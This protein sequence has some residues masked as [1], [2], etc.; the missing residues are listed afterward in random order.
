MRL[1]SLR[2]ENRSSGAS[3]SAGPEPDPRFDRDQELRSLLTTFAPLPRQDELP[4]EEP[5]EEEA[6]M[7][8]PSEPKEEADTETEAK[9]EPLEPKNDALEERM[10]RT[11]VCFSNVPGLCPPEPPRAGTCCI[12]KCTVGVVA[13]GASACSEC[14]LVESICEDFF[15]QRRGTGNEEVAQ[16]GE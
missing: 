3:S 15:S 1:G 12:C 14:S 9:E 16:A 8:E 13:P 5:K 7:E 2:V 4:K 10:R 6:A 11:A